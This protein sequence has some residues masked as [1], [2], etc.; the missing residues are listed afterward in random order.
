[1]EHELSIDTCSDRLLPLRKVGRIAA[2]SRALKARSR[3]L[4]KTV[5]DFGRTVER[6]RDDNG[7]DN[8]STRGI[9]SK[10]DALV[11]RL[12]VP[13]YACFDAECTVN[14]L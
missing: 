2:I 3:N 6:E 7:L 10:V 9:S 14:S 11:R 13:H 1:M 4:V 8:A 5:A 12:R